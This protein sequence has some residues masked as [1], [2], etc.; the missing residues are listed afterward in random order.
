MDAQTQS[1]AHAELIGDLLFGAD[2]IADFL[3]S[4]GLPTTANHVYYAK[5]RHSLPIGRYNKHLCASKRKLTRA[6]HAMVNGA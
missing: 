4:L 2:M 6:V 5:K 1:E 3:T